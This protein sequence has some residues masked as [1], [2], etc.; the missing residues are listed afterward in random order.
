MAGYLRVPGN[1]IEVV[2]GRKSGTWEKVVLKDCWCSR[3]SYSADFSLVIE[4]L[5]VRDISI[6]EDLAFIHV[7]QKEDP[8]W[9]EKS[10]PERDLNEYRQVDVRGDTR[11]IKHLRQH[12]CPV[13]HAKVGRLPD[14]VHGKQMICES[15]RRL[16]TY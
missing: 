8:C 1:D 13:C 3:E 5:K 2:I 14:N 12:I 11:S 7:V 16:Y 10:E 9:D 15:C 4:A 6:P